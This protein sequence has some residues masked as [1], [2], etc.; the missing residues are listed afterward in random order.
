MRLSKALA[1]AGLASRR[2]AE[3]WIQEG[4]VSVNGTPI[5]LPET[6][7]NWEEDELTLEGKRLEREKKHYFLFHKPKNTFSSCKRRGQERLV[8]DFF[9][10]HLRL[11]PVGRLDKDTTGLLLIT[12]DGLFSQKV[13]HPSANREKEYYITTS[14]P[15]QENQI[16]N[17][18][19]GLFLQGQKLIPVR[20]AKLNKKLLSVTVKEGKKREVRHM[21]KKAGIF[22]FSLKRIRIDTL[23][24]GRLKEGQYRCLTPSE[25]TSFFD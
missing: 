1:Q 11:F 25:I 9:P 13:I 24:L 22:S 17:I 6:Q 12:N 20:V 3:K 23:H 16:E 5:F 7:V 21:A 18:K 15:L 8:L 2:A 10:K 4:K 19:K 14:F